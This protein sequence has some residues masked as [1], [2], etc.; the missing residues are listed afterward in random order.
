[1][2]L[3]VAGGVL[4]SACGGGGDKLPKATEKANTPPKAETTDGSVVRSERIGP[5]SSLSRLW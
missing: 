4:L 2:A 1:M 5:T 3:L